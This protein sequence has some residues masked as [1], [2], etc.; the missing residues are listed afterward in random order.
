MSAEREPI[1]LARV[2]G[3]Y[4]VLGWVRLHSF[5]DPRDAVFDYRDCY[6]GQGQDRRP[7]RIVAG[8]KHGKGLIA[9]FAGI[10]DRD[11]AQGLVGAELAVDRQQMPDPEPGHYYWADLQGL[12]VQQVDGTDLGRVSH[13]LETGA[14]DVLVVQGTEEVLIPFLTGSVIKNVDLDAGLIVVDW[15]WE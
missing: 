7:A 10:E 12:A 15:E 3:V 9:R 4:G 6:L 8:K 1:V 2:S 11:A 14:N 13:L 5:T